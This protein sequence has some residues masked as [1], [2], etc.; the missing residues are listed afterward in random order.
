MRP[1]LGLGVGFSSGNDW[2]IESHFAGAASSAGSFLSTNNTPDMIGV[3]RAGI[4]VM[5]SDH[6][7]AT[8][9]YNGS[10]ANG[11]SA[12]AG[13]LKLTCR[14]LQKAHGLG[15]LPAPAIKKAPG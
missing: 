12:N 2:E 8:A 7:G 5:S 13:A 11:F 9:H 6:F 1:Y 10:F 14:F 15:L 4:E 3:I